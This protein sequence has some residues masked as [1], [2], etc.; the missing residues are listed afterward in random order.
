MLSSFPARPGQEVASQGFFRLRNRTPAAQRETLRISL[1]SSRPRAFPSSENR[2]PANN[3][4]LFEMESEQG[5]SFPMV[6]AC[7]LLRDEVSPPTTSARLEQARGFHPRGQGAFPRLDPGAWGGLRVGCWLGE[8]LL[9]KTHTTHT[10]RPGLHMQFLAS[11]LGITVMV[12]YT[13]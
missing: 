10:E 2:S 6:A 9:P 7:Q 4:A 11:H 1:P 8:I 12:T 13:G 3:G 5:W